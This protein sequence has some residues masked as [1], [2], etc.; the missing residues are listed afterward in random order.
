M[1]VCTPKL[2]EIRFHNMISAKK[3]KMCLIKQIPHLNDQNLICNNKFYEIIAN[4]HA[5]HLSP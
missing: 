3:P 2:H 4:L 1:I 5:T